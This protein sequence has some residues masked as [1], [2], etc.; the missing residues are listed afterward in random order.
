MPV[1]YDFDGRVTIVRMTGLYLT[2]DVRAALIAAFA[3]P[4]GA[5]AA[6]LL[7]DIRGSRSIVQRTADEVRAMAQFIASHGDHFGRRLALLADSGAAFG[8]MR[9]GAVA[10]EQ[11]GVEAAVFRHE[12]DAEEWLG[13]ERPA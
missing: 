1:S 12:S 2:A 11:Q 10:V 6:G 4:R 7:F 5:N 8:L 3:D 9:L 13:A